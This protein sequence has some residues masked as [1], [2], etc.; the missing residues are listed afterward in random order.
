LRNPSNAGRCGHAL[1][2]FH[3]ADE[4]GAIQIFYARDRCDTELTGY[5]EQSSRIT[6]VFAVEEVGLKEPFCD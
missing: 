2:C 3:F 5:A 6:N 1:R 4:G